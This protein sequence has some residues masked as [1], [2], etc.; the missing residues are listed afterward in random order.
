MLFSICSSQLSSH[1]LQAKSKKSQP[2]SSAKFCDYG[3]A[4]TLLNLKW[5]FRA[6]M[7]KSHSLRMTAWGKKH[8]VSYAENT[9]SIEKVTGSQDDDFVGVLKK[10]IPRRDLQFYGPFLE[11]FFDKTQISSLAALQTS[12]G[13]TR[14]GSL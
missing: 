5:L 14:F 8:P 2:L 1:K 6:E 10:N 11:M 9:K 13:L 3:F 12:T 4:T 7:C